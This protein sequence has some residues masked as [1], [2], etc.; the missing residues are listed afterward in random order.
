MWHLLIEYR[1]DASQDQHGRS[2]FHMHKPPE[3]MHLISLYVSAE[4]RVYSIL[5]AIPTVKHWMVR[6]KEF[7][8][9]SATE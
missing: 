3:I 4:Q 6:V 8:I 9:I 2:H 1:E 5:C 7:V